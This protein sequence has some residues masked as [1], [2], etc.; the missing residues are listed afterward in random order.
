MTNEN[1][2]DYGG[3]GINL[4]GK[5]QTLT[6]L[7]EA[8]RL[9]AISFAPSDVGRIALQESDESFWLL[10][11]VTPITWILIGSGIQPESWLVPAWYIDPV[12]GNDGADGLTPGTAIKHWGELLL[13]W[14]TQSPILPQETIVTFLSDQ[15]DLSDPV[16]ANP[17]VGSIVGTFAIQGSLNPVA[18]AAGSF[19]AVVPLN[20]ATGTKWRVTDNTKPAGF[21]SAY[22]GLM[23]HDLTTDTRFWVDADLG[24]ST[25]VVTQAFA[26]ASSTSNPAIIPIGNGDGYQV[27]K[28]T[29]VYIANFTPY[30]ASGFNGELRRIWNFATNAEM[31]CGNGNTYIY[32]SRVDDFMLLPYGG[33]IT[34]CYLFG[35]QFGGEAYLL[36]GLVTF[37]LVMAVGGGQGT[38][39]GDTYVNAPAMALDGTVIIGAAYFANNLEVPNINSLGAATA[40]LFV[41]NGAIY[42]IAAVWG[43]GAIN[44]HVGGDL[45]YDAPAVGAFLNAGGLSLDGAGV[46]SS[47]NAGTGLWA[48]GIALTPT[49]LDAPVPGGF[50]G[51]AY[52]VLGSK[53]RMIA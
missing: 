23:I 19:T 3:V 38:I 21:W 17:Q 32:E 18:G 14:G 15:P 40:A 47:Y 16:I 26:D 24:A 36:G 10:K 5:V 33:N 34:N 1:Q 30:T 37:L 52:G 48:G 11:S 9:A 13:R 49:N 50:G 43:P 2:N 28:P 20:R 4:P 31:F 42:G 25:A 27:V 29:R 44:V 12:N 53:I 8:D 39:D 41:S 6:F 46:A 51:V 35:L 45:G 7:D 22:V